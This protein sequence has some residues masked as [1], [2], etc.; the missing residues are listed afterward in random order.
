MFDKLKDVKTLKQKAEEIAAEH[1]DKID[2]GLEKAGA[3]IDEKTGGKHGDKIDAAV[4][5]AQAFVDKLSG[6][7]RE[8][9]A[10]DGGDGGEGDSVA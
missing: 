5:K 3:F 9:V 4:D 7:A 6:E 1:G 8:D 2:D 10:R